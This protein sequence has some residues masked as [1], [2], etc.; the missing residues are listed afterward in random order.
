MARRSWPFW[1]SRPLGRFRMKSND[2]LNHVSP[3]HLN[4][5][6]A[7]LRIDHEV[8]FPIA[9][10][11]ADIRG[12][13]AQDQINKIFRVLARILSGPGADCPAQS[14]A[15]EQPWARPIATGAEPR[16]TDAFVCSSA[17]IPPQKS[18]SMPGSTTKRPCDK[19]MEK[20]T[21]MLFFKR[22][23]L[24]AILPTPGTNSSS[25]PDPA[26]KSTL[27]DQVFGSP[28]AVLENEQRSSRT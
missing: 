11:V 26:N 20:P 9:F 6:N 23:S 3:R 22:C 28:S 18:S 19:P 21:R 8:H 2:S 12:L 10:P 25:S 17:T 4:R 14:I 5:R 15:R 7:M 27:I 24:K 1:P 16:S 13:A